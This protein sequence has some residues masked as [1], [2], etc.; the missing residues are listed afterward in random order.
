[1][2]VLFSIL[3]ADRSVRALSEALDAVPQQILAHGFSGSMKHAA[4]AAAYDGSPRPVSYTHL[5]LPTTPYV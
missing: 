4:T 1:M 2:N 3:R 5:T